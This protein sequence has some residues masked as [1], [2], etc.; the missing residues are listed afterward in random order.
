MKRGTMVLLLGLALG[1]AAFGG[2]YYLGTARC[3]SLMRQS[4]PELAWLKQEYNLS[5]SEFARISQLHEAYLPGCLERC[6]HIE[7]VNEK[8][9]RLLP[10]AGSVTPE[11]QDLLA[12]RARTRANCESEMLK[13]FLAVSRTMPAEQ[14]KRYLA[15]VEERTL[16]QPQAMELSHHA[17]HHH[18]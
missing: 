14:G 1:F 11:I 4:Q 10:P 16:L 15:W 8:L 6:R 5:D 7:E 17:G 2:V 12:E 18:P 9:R 3:R 13:H